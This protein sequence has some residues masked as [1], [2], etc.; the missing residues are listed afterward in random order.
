M[1]H[2]DEPQENE[3]RDLTA[4][5]LELETLLGYRFKEKELLVRS[6]TH[7]SFAHE[8]ENRGD[9]MGVESQLGFLPKRD[10]ER[11][12]FLGD[13]VVGLILGQLLMGGFSEACEGKLSRWRSGLVSRRTMAGIAEKLNLGKYL[14][15]GRG[16]FR[17]GGATKGS[18]LGA[19]LEAIVGALYVDGGLAPAEAFLKKIYSPLMDALASE[20]APPA[21]LQDQKTFLQERTQSQYKCTPAYRLIDTWGRE[22]EKSFRIE[23]VIQGKVIASGVGKSKKEAEQ[24]AAGNALGVLEF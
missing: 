5:L 23:I 15:L 7:S 21:E 20:G 11:L 3:T 10:N 14:L 13:A 18:I 4:L 22:H 1:A 17:S 6:L 24:N 19:A 8:L 9:L 2:L 16:E 12:E